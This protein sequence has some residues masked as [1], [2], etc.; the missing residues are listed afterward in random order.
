VISIEVDKI[1]P[2]Q[3]GL[4]LGCVVR[5]GEGGPVRFCQAY[6]PIN[7]FDAECRLALLRLWD[8]MVSRHISE[9]PLF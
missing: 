8:E 2:S 6:V 9:E 5:Y 7:L 3:D 4:L 1:L